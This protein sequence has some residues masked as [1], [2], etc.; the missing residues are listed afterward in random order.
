MTG[1]YLLSSPVFQR[2]WWHQWCSDNGWC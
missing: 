2:W 1:L